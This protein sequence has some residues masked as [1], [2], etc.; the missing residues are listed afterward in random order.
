MPMTY[1]IDSDA[2]ML[3]I[4]GEGAITQAERIETMQAFVNDVSFRPGLSTLFDVSAA[5]TTPSLAELEQ[6]VMFVQRHAA[7]I[8]RKR[9]AIVTSRPV[10]FGV[11]RQFQALAESSPLDVEV[12]T[13][14][15][16][17]VGW[18]RTG[19]R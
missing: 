7:S 9:L 4:V 18:L 11:A 6:I 10:T 1:R 16:A 12:F 8:G 17:A 15:D 19:A 2:G 5:T 3:F 13:D 14:R